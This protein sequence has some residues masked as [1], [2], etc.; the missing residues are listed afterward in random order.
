MNHQPQA[1]R[2]PSTQ[3]ALVIGV[4]T[5]AS[6]LI[7]LAT[8]AVANRA[9]AQTPTVHVDPIIYP[10]RGQSPTEQS[11]DRYECYEWSKRQTGFDPTQSQGHASMPAA[12]S[13]M[14][15]S[16]VS[17]SASTAGAMVGGAASGATIAELTHHDVG[18]G[19]AIGALGGGLVAQAKQQQ[20]QAQM[21][22]QQAAQAQAAQAQAA[23]RN[24]QR[25]AY[26]RALGACMEARGYTVR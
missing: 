13:S 3:R 15:S 19:A 14:R 6:A 11:R 23:S 2:S 4:A 22:Q 8:S 16:S 17:A 7:V 1:T 12:K 24:Q 25:S 21:K 10:A 18:R 20:Q 26:D 9:E 5:A